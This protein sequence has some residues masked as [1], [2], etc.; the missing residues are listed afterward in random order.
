MKSHMLAAALMAALPLP[1]LAQTQQ[2]RPPIA[3]YWLNVE[4][5]GG[6]GMEMPPGMGG[7]MPPG[8]QGGKRMKLDLG[9]TQAARGEPRAMHVIP[10]GLTMGPSLPLVTPR[11]ERTP[12]REPDEEREY[13]RPKGRM[14]IY[15][16]CG[17]RVRHPVNSYWRS[18]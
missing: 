1:L 14:L 9:S 18:R 13:E 4:T 15:W 16:G 17:T 2:I 12:A 6:M 11:A 10:P 5:A 8:M 3:L 7:M